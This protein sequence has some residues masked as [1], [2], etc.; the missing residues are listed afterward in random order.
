MSLRS[1]STMR[2]RGGFAT[3]FAGH[4]A[5][6]DPYRDPTTF[7][8]AERMTGGHGGRRK[9]QAWTQDG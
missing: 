8:R 5:A 4:F 1:L 3:A 9:Q 7:A 2:A 6:G